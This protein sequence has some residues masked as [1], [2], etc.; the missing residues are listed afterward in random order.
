[1][2]HNVMNHYVMDQLRNRNQ[3]LEVLIWHDIQEDEEVNLQKYYIPSP[4]I[5]L[6]T[7]VAHSRCQY[8][9]RNLSNL[10]SKNYC[11]VIL[12]GNIVNYYVTGY[13]TQFIK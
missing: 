12:G 8:Q 5:L 11:Y 1:M 13:A 4:S 9:I 6:S 10:A 7:S 2:N 3:T